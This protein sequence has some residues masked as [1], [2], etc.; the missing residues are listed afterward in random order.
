MTQAKS[1]SALLDLA[2]NQR[3]VTGR[4]NLNLSA[5]IFSKTKSR[6]ETEETAE[7]Y[8]RKLVD[9]S[10]VSGDIVELDIFALHQVGQAGVFVHA[11]P[12]GSVIFISEADKLTQNTLAMKEVV[13]A[14]VQAVSARNC[15]LVM[16]CEEK[17]H[18]KILE[19]DAG[20]PRRIPHTFDLDTAPPAVVAKELDDDMAIMKPM[21]RV[22]PRNMHMPP[23]PNI[24]RPH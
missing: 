14:I 10:L 22:K 23:R 16:V 4:C 21:G 2:E 13:P 20:L 8:A 7:R 17:N 9:S 5:A 24:P 1:L 19:L 18:R 12:D 3:Q 6:K 11:I 15:T